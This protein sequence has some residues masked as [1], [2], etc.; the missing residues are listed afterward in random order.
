MQF[1]RQSV[2]YIY[3]GGKIVNLNHRKPKY[4]TSLP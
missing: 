3:D 1:R 2:Y 4:Y